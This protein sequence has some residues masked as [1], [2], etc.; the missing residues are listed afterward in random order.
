VDVAL[1]S[2]PAL[3]AGI[4]AEPLLVEDICVIARPDALDI[5]GTSADIAILHQVPLVLTGIPK[6]GI[7]LELEPAAGRRHVSLRPVIEVESF[8][9]AR[10]LVTA[11]IGWTVH[12]AI[13]F[14]E[15]IELGKL[16]AVPLTG[17]SLERSIAFAVDRPRS[18]ATLALSAVLRGTATDMITQRQ[19]P[20]ARL[21]PRV[22]PNLG[23]GS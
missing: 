22:D 11:G 7:R 5:E 19:W 13:A 9:A 1:L 6:A 2:G 16:R 15:D 4:E 18:H 3:M 12:V 17:I 23:K 10:T 8:N 21:S 20:N 14:M